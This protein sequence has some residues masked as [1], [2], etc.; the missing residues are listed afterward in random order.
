MRRVASQH[1]TATIVMLYVIEP[2]N[3]FWKDVRQVQLE[4]Q[5]NKAKALFRLMRRKLTNEGFEPCRR[6]DHPR[7]QESRGDPE[8]N[9]RGRRHRHSRAGGVDRGCGT[10]AAG[11]VPG[12]RAMAGK[13]PIPITIVPGE[14]KLDEIQAWLERL[15]WRL[16]NIRPE[17]LIS[18]L[19]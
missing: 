19:F 14:L 13:F 17:T 11:L 1:T 9:R 15:T 5:T 8:A 12:R 7:G 2:D 16:S 10:W 4:E 6:G 18:E 3:Q